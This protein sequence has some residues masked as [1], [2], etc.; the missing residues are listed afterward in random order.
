MYL[1]ISMSNIYLL[2][3]DKEFW[4]SQFL[5]FIIVLTGNSSKKFE[6]RLN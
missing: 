5:D 2:V 4:Q 3:W 1:L 6:S